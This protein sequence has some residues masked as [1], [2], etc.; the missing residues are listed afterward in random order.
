VR[1]FQPSRQDLQGI[2]RYGK[3]QIFDKPAAEAADLRRLVADIDDQ[4]IGHRRTS[5]P[6]GRQVS[7]RLAQRLG[8]A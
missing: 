7:G 4:V 2:D 1:S 5:Q 3:L 8:G 6:A